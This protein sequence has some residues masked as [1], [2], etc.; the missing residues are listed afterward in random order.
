MTM[1]SFKTM[2][3]CFPLCHST[4][5]FHSLPVQ[6][7]LSSLQH[8]E[9]SELPNLR[10]DWGP[11]LD[12]W[13]WSPCSGKDLHRPAK[14]PEEKLCFAAIEETRTFP[15]PPSASSSSSPTVQMIVPRRK[16]GQTSRQ[17]QQPVVE[18]TEE[19]VAKLFR[20]PLP[21]AADMLG[22]GATSMK[23]VCRRLGIKK[24]P[25]VRHT[26]PK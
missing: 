8:R 3:L 15:E 13:R 26:V 23:N 2:D 22:I 25:Y 17:R 14:V 7:P 6:S 5:I 9:R 16:P 24:W 21:Q 20:Y 10:C 19:I 4:D 11:C 12:S 18:I 1:V